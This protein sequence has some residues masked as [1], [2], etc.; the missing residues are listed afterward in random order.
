LR[1]LLVTLFRGSKKVPP[2]LEMEPAGRATPSK[3][4]VSYRITVCL[5]SPWPTLISN[6]VLPAVMRME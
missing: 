4:L 1:Y 5:L 6:E 2:F 3:L